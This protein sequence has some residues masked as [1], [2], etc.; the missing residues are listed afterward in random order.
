MREDG[1]LSRGRGRVSQS[2]RPASSTPNVHG[3]SVAT[4]PGAWTLLLAILRSA[5]KLVTPQT[6]LIACGHRTCGPRPRHRTHS[7]WRLEP[8][9]RYAMGA[10]HVGAPRDG[11][12]TA[13]SGPHDAGPS[14]GDVARSGDSE[15]S[16]PSSSGRWAAGFSDVPVLQ[17]I[18]RHE[19]GG[20]TTVERWVPRTYPRCRHVTVK[21]ASY[22][23]CLKESMLA[24]RGLHRDARLISRA[25]GM[26]H[27]DR[28]CGACVIRLGS[29]I[30]SPWS[31]SGPHGTHRAPVQVRGGTRSPRQRDTASHDLRMFHTSV[32][33][34]ICGVKPRCLVC[35]A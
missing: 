26:L 30:P 12:G 7:A 9:D 24:T 15:F 11:N 20:G 28:L 25:S 8:Q 21:M 14:P 32:P 10:P 1:N 31:N 6:P 27:C 4:S 35:L 16:T 3:L 17:G 23:V 5:A 33:E 19:T 34:T 13:E 18:P 2:P 29:G 22:R